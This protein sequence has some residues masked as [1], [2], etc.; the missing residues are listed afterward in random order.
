MRKNQVFKTTLLASAM[1]MALPA[2]LQAAE[3][4]VLHWWTSGGEAAALNVLKQDL[5]GQS[6]GW[7]DMPVAGGGGTEAMTVLR[8]R[9]QAG[10]SPTAVQ[11]LGFDIQDWAAE[12]ATANLNSLAK[13]EGWDKVVPAALPNAAKTYEVQLR[14]ATIA[15]AFCQKTEFIIT[16]T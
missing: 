9:V 7:K 14:T 16:W 1:S 10:N 8:S 11:M 5:E 13:K 12:G 6:I 3:V 2:S 15:I 4:E